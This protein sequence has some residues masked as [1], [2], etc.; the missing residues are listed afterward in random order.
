MSRFPTFLACCL[1]CT[2]YFA[3]ASNLDRWTGTMTPVKVTATQ[4]SAIPKDPRSN[5]MQFPKR[6][7]FLWRDAGVVAGAPIGVLLA[8]QGPSLVPQLPSAQP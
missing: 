4:I 6:L 8:A 1:F 5:V 7:L 3:I 2:T